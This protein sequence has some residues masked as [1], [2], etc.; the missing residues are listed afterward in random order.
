MS[1]TLT[2][3]IKKVLEQLEEVEREEKALYKQ[4]EK[5]ENKKYKL[6]EKL[7]EYINKINNSATQKDNN[8]QSSNF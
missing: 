1:G 5:I 2:S 6:K 8:N 3:K 4:I 7:Q